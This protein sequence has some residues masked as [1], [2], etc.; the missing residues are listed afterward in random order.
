VIERP[1][2]LFGF[3]F[4]FLVAPQEL[5]I[6]SAPS[7]SAACSA[8]SR[9]EL[10]GELASTSRILQLWQ[11]ACAVSMSSEISR[12]QPVASSASAGVVVRAVF[13]SAAVFGNG[14]FEV[15]PFSL[16]CL[17]QPLAA[18]HSGRPNSSL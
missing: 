16:T 2:L 1:F 6:S 7:V 17:K 13:S 3:G 14:R 8:A 11:T 10:S 12:P 9:C 5:L 4:A 18:V 15:S